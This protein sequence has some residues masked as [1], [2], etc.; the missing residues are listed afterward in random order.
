LTNVAEALEPFSYMVDARQ[1]VASR[2]I[3]NT[4]RRNFLC[5]IPDL[6]FAIRSLCERAAQF[7]WTFASEETPGQYL[8][9]VMRFVFIRGCLV[10]LAAIVFWNAAR[11]LV[12]DRRAGGFS[13]AVQESM[14]CSAYRNQILFRIVPRVA[15][16]F[17]VVDF[18]A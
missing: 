16:K 14:T 13:P 10:V 5:A 1:T 2:T 3:G 8:S 12:V 4:L 18:Q 9:P 7:V 17:L 11:W 15:A 6:H